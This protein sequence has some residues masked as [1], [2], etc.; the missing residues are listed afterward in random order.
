[1]KRRG[2]ASRTGLQTCSMACPCDSLIPNQRLIAHFLVT[3][4]V[5]DSIYGNLSGA[6]T[7]LDISGTSSRFG[8]RFVNVERQATRRE[9]QVGSRIQYSDLHHRRKTVVRIYVVP[10][11]KSGGLLERCRALCSQEAGKPGRCATNHRDQ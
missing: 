7:V 1:M 10:T 3:R 6:N 5:N 11:K 8:D 2:D 9:S 4:P